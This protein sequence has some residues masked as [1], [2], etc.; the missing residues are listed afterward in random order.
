MFSSFLS[1]IIKGAR[2]AASLVGSEKK[3]LHLFLPD[4]ADFLRTILR[5]EIRKAVSAAERDVKN[6]F[7]RLM[8]SIAGAS[9]IFSGFILLMSCAAF[10]LRSLVP[11]KVAFFFAGSALAA[12]GYIVIRRGLKNA[13][14]RGDDTSPEGIKEGYTSSRR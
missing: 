4:A 8:L 11:P 9:L 13:G 3:L 14:A 12:G 10:I 7:F 5:A 1:G 6:N 2:L